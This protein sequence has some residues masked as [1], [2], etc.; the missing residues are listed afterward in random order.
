[1]TG[2]QTCAL[3]IC[4][5]IYVIDFGIYKNP[6]DSTIT[7]TGF[8]PHTT[9]FASPE[10]LNG[11]RD[12]ISYRTDFFSIGIIAYV[13][14]YSRL[15]FGTTEDDIRANFDSGTLNYTVNENCALASFFKKV[16][17]KDISGRPR[18][19]NLFLEDI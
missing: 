8:Q 18:D 5:K 15:P 1:M 4:G 14:K 6:D 3:P 10:Q 19:V 2:V 7:T 12:A 11:D 9:G 13:L 16:F 17:V